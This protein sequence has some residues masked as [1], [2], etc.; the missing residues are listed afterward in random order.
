MILAGDIG[1]GLAGVSWAQSVFTCPV[2]YVPGNHEYYGRNIDLHDDALHDYVAGSHVHVLQ[3]E[4]LVL[5]GVRFLGT[6]LWTDFNAHGDVP[7]AA[8]MA[9]DRLSD[10]YVIGT[11]AG[12]AIKPSE[13]I[14]R[15]E[16]AVA[17][18]RQTLSVPF[19]GPTVVITHHLPSY[20][21]VAARFRNDPLTPAFASTLDDLVATS[22]ALLWIHGHGHDSVDY[23]L[24]GTRVVCNPRGY[25]GEENVRESPPF[26]WDYTVELPV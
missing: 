6:T 9:Q 23:A 15:H 4:E 8:L 13:V 22:G 16:T 2:I 3:N 26:R 20:Q 21:S 18:L 1:E 11:S 12:R 14:S 25:P 10:Y 24:G 19:S 5:G 7:Q 17:W